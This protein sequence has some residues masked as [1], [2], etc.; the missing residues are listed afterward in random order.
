MNKFQTPHFNIV[1]AKL[2]QTVSKHRQGAVPLFLSVSLSS[3]GVKVETYL[4]R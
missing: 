2:Q 3:L 1:F 4:D